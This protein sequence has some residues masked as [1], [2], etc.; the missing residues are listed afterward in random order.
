MD[1]FLSI[2]DGSQYIH[3]NRPDAF[4]LHTHTIKYSN[5]P[6]WKIITFT[7]FLYAYRK[8][9]ITTYT[10]TTEQLHILQGFYEIVQKAAKI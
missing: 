9:P 8:T 4:S 5:T 1:E 7:L 10:I 3:V 2:T 6:E